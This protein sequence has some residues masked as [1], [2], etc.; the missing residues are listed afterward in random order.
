MVTPLCEAV[1][2]F[3]IFPEISDDNA[4]VRLDSKLW[5][6]EL[7][8]LHWLHSSHLSIWIHSLHHSIIIDRRWDLL[9]ERAKGS[10]KRILLFHF[11]L[12][13]SHPAPGRLGVWIRRYKKKTNS[14]RV[15]DDW[16]VLLWNPPPK[17]MCLSKSEWIKY[18]TVWM[19]AVRRKQKNA[20]PSKFPKREGCVVC[21]AFSVCRFS[22]RFQFCHHETTGPA[23]TG[24]WK[25]FSFHFIWSTE[26]A[27]LFCRCL[28]FSLYLCVFV[29]LPSRKQVEYWWTDRQKKKIKRP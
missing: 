14:R 3:Q 16:A 13:H 22:S 26:N 29:C 27:H 21:V 12:H 11:A 20:Q 8:A 1:S 6:C 2:T 28:F 24:L 9:G 25:W 17:P 19:R 7:W 10:W 15:N 18:L 5:S 4:P 23:R